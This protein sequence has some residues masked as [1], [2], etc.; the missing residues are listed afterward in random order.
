[1]LW[2]VVISHLKATVVGVKIGIKD[3]SVA[4]QLNNAA[5]MM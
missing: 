3:S 2:S 1:M 4:G 5:T